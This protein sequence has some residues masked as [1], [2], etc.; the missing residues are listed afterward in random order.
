MN[1]RVDA[2]S[3]RFGGLLAVDEVS[4][5]YDGQSPLGIIGPNGSGKTTLFNLITG[6]LRADTGSVRIDHV[7]LTKL[8]A[9]EIARTGIRRTFQQTMLFAGLTVRESV[10]V[11]LRA[12][13]RHREGTLSAAESDATGF[14]LSLCGLTQHADRLADELSFG[15]ARLLGIAMALTG[16]CRILL[17]DEPAA[18]MSNGEAATLASVIEDLARRD[19]GIAVVDHNIKFLFDLCPRILVLDKGRLVADGPPAEIRN[20]AKVISV[21][22]GVP[23]A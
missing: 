17:L 5:D 2:L 14:L 9:D 23:H 16:P 6:F 13:G 7:D 18:G 3:R 12:A 10:D 4:F 20:D 19:I 15:Y 8:R 21:Y 22:L 1:L 11:G